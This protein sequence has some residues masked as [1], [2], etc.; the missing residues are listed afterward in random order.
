QVTAGTST[1][2]TVTNT[3]CFSLAGVGAGQVSIGPS[4]GLTAVTVSNASAG[5]LT[6][7]FTI[8]TNAPT[9]AHTVTITA[10]NVAATATFTILAPTPPPPPPPPPTCPGGGRCC[11]IS[12]DG[13]V[14]T[15]CV[16][17][18]QSCP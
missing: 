1:S 6:L 14:C 5:Q 4:T 16:G 7:S 9:G 15:L 12:P 11:E 18:T 13:T 3:G 17:A 2:L 10:N 8:A